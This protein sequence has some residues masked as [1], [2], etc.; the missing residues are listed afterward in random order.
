MCWPAPHWREWEEKSNV[1]ANLLFQSHSVQTK[2]KTRISNDVDSDTVRIQRIQILLTVLW[3]SA[4][5]LKSM[6]PVS[7]RS[8]KTRIGNEIRLLQ[9]SNRLTGQ[10]KRTSHTVLRLFLLW[11]SYTTLSAGPGPSQ[12]IPVLHTADLSLR[13]RVHKQVSQLNMQLK[14]FMMSVV[15]NPQ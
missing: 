7:F 2:I 3:T 13:T 10:N 4:D 11:V 5:W 6:S 1:T 9:I 8:F 15:L 14:L 12:L